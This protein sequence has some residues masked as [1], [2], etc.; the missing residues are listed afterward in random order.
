MLCVLL[1]CD[2]S[3]SNASKAFVLGDTLASRLPAETGALACRA[4]G[5]G[6][7]AAVLP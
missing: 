3:G 4:S 1:A 6:P 2:S 7:S 5:T